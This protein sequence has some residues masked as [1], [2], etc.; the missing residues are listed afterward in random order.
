[1]P[2]IS[3]NGAELFAIEEGEGDPIVLVHGSLA[4]YRT[5]VLQVREFS[6]RHR[7]IAYSRR[8]HFPNVSAEHDPQYGVAAQANDLA[9]VIR[10]RAGGIAHVVTS[11]FGS[12]VA[13]HAWQTSPELFKTL[14]LCEPPLMPWL[15]KSTEGKDLHRGVAEAQEASVRA[16]NAGNDKEGV[17]FFSDMAIGSGVFDAMQPRSQARIMDNRYELSLE[18]KAP[19]ESYFPQLACGRLSQLETPVLLLSSGRSPAL[20]RVITEELAKCLPRAR[21]ETIPASTHI[22]HGTNPAA[23]NQAVTAFVGDAVTAR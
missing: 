7:V 8:Y 3:V 19:A 9:E 21:R 22:I 11:S 14:T 17:R 18:M 10:T 5:W 23:F 2:K 12:C 13:L 4:D 6:K 1:M 20:Y 15:L 16:F